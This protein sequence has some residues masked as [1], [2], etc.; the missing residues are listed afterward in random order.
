MNVDSQIIT[1]PLH[2][3]SHNPGLILKKLSTLT[4]C[5]VFINHL[6]YI[7]NILSN[8]IQALQFYPTFLCKMAGSTH[9][10]STS[11]AT[12]SDQDPSPPG[13]GIKRAKALSNAMGQA[14]AG[15]PGSHGSSSSGNED[16]LPPGIGIKRA[17]A[18]SNVMGQTVAGPSGSYDPS[19]SGNQDPF[20]REIGIKRGMALSNAIGQAVAGPP[21]SHGSFSSGNKQASGGK[22]KRTKMA[23]VKNFINNISNTR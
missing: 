15:P 19:S 2:S 3:H 21:G 20:H 6:L 17:K 11:R 8:S 22:P 12:R 5:S 7:C 4:L 13:I 16:P 18:L 14:V 23:S 10:H 9:H 1:K